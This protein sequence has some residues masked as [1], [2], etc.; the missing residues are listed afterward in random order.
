MEDTENKAP[1]AVD[2]G[3]DGAGKKPGRHRHHHRGNRGGHPQ[4]NSANARLQEGNANGEQPSRNGQP[5]APKQNGE[6]KPNNENNN[7]SNGDRNR[8]NRNRNNRRPYE[9]GIADPYG[10][11]S[12]ETVQ[13]LAD[14]RAQIVLKAADGSVPAPAPHA[15]EIPAASVEAAP[16]ALPVSA[17]EEVPEVELFPDPAP[18]DPGEG[19]WW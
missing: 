7:R 15:E 12:G 8:R 6:R 4:E 2:G 18:E 5:G 14:L 11:P 9:K 17:G 1:A 13:S 3:T 19:E 10:I 16:E